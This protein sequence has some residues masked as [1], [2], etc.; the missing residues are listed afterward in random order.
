MKAAIF[1]GS[2]QPL[3][4][5]E[6]PKPRPQKDQVLIRLKAAALNHLDLWIMEE[7]ATVRRP[8]GIVLGSDGVGTVTDVGEDVDPLFVGSEVI[9]N[10]SMEWGLNPMVQGDSFKILGFPD[11]GT[12]AEFVAVSKK[13]IFETPDGFTPEECAAIPLSGLTAYRALFSKARLRAKEKV[14]ITGIGGG[15]ALWALTFAVAYGARV[16]VT[17]GSEEKIQQAVNLGATGGFNYKNAGWA[18]EAAKTA[19]GGFDIIIDSAGGDQFSKLVELALPGGRIV[20]FGRTAGTITNI[21]TRLLYWKQLSI[22]GS[23]MGTR[24]EFLSMLDFVESRKL[25]PIVDQVFPLDRLA[26]AVDRLKSGQQFGKV[27]IRIE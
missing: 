10:P 21:P 16:Y 23:T 14:L 2:G 15:A 13:Y 19:G 11:N 18:D 3:Q 12:L 25:K 5:G 1:K 7:Q 27:V 17:S 20:N 8:E 22:F 24:D 4:V 9:I 26:D 6:F